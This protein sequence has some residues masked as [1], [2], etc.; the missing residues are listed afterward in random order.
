[1]SKKPWIWPACRSIV[2]TRSAPAAVI[3]LAT[4][5]A[6]IGVR[7]AGFAVLPGVA[8]IGDDG[9]DPPRR[10]ALQRVE[11]D[12][13][14]HQMV[15]RRVRGRLDHEHV[16]AAD[17][18]VDLDKHFHVGEP[19]HAGSR[20]RQ[21]EIGRD[22]LGERPIAVAGK[23]LHR[24]RGNP[25]RRARSRGFT[26]RRVLTNPRRRGNPGDGASRNGPRSLRSAAG[27][28]DRRSPAATPCLLKAAS[29]R[30][31]RRDEHF[32]PRSTGFAARSCPNGSTITGT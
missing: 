26:R 20:E 1:M 4:S 15:V 18:L 11:R 3:R 9:R 8:V 24:R 7:G 21:A 16:L 27:S 6:E 14:L 13:Q 17:V 22:R 28:C 5:L 12:Q 10:A 2:S 30:L 23:D 29:I 31:E 32:P 25:C 19:A